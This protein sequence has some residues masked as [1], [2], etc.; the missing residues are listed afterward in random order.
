[1][2]GTVRGLRTL[3]SALRPNNGGAEA[4]RRRRNERDWIATL[5]VTN[6]HLLGPAFYAALLHSEALVDLPV[7]VRK[8]LGYLY[9]E[10]ARRNAAVRR[11][12]IEML[13][14]LGAHGVEAMLLKGCAA[15]LGKLHAGSGVRMLRDIDLLVRPQDLSATLD[16]LH[17]LGYRVAT[18]FPDGHHAHADL[19]RPGDPA[20][21]DLHV[22]L[23]DPRH[24]LPASE[25]WDR[26]ERQIYDGV[27][28]RVPCPT[29][30]VLHNVLH[31]QI[32]FL[33]NFYRGVLDLHQLYDLAV[34]MRRFHTTIDWPFIE[35][36]LRAH[37]LQS[38]LQTY[39]LAASR[40]FG[41]PWPLAA[42]PGAAT[43][44][45]YAQCLVGLVAPVLNLA[46]MP[47]GN[48]RGALAWHRMRGLYGETAPLIGLQI[49]H[50]W[51]FLRKSNTRGIVHRVFRTK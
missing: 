8:Y 29:D 7:E 16:T 26:S 2:I 44:L 24:V 28:Y 34:A 40:L 27:T 43:H 1:M 12:A 20:T 25:V 21:V 46:I 15:L 33:G 47:I 45:F 18:R 4:A 37:H 14:A 51:H 9:R 10:N 13:A 36:R 49:S 30:F 35:G 32:H 42:R 3:S 6:Q 39:V 22:E 11:Q 5:R 50:A 17:G 38:P 23:V 48:L 19:R 41:A 31:A